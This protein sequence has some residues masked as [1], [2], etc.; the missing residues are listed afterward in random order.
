MRVG[1][2]FIRMF[3]LFLG[4]YDGCDRCLQ[5][6]SSFS[7]AGFVEIDYRDVNIENIF[8]YL[9]N[10]FSFIRNILHRHIFYSRIFYIDTFFI[11]KIFGNTANVFHKFIYVSFTSRQLIFHLLLESMEFF[12]NLFLNGSFII[13]QIISRHF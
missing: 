12:F 8:V 5:F 11:V 10:S 7:Q 9:C 4:I 13:L 2:V 3:V 6:Q 1:S